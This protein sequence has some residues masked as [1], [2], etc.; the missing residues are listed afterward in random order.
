MNIIFAAIMATLVQ[1]NP[2][3][4]S[5]WTYTGFNQPV[6]VHVGECR[7]KDIE[8]ELA[9][10]IARTMNLPS[11]AVALARVYCDPWTI[12]PGGETLQEVGLRVFNS[13]SEVNCP[14]TY[15]SMLFGCIYGL[16]NG[17]RPGWILVFRAHP[18][19]MRQL[20]DTADSMGLDRGAFVNDKGIEC[21]GSLQRYADLL[22]HEW[23]HAYRGLR[24]GAEMSAADAEMIARA[25]RAVVQKLRFRV[26]EQHGEFIRSHE[27]SACR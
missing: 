17:Y 13:H 23:H 7:A 4:V 9:R 19:I 15:W 20:L 22:V 10:R 6:P 25:N 8:S 12:G 26:R 14:R 27:W 18:D 1:Y 11:S 16:A 21:L 3:P 2:A 24:H 5:I